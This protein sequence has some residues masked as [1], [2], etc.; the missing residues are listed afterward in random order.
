MTSG[1]ENRFLLF[2]CQ[3]TEQLDRK[4]TDRKQ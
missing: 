4:H 3:L 2:D 1:I